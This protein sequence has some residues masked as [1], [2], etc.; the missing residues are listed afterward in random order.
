MQQEIEQKKIA[1][2]GDQFG[3]SM[4]IS[5]GKVFYSFFSYKSRVSNDLSTELIK[6]IEK[7]SI[8]VLMLMT[9]LE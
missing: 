2:A 6:K 9:I 8:Q 4:N 1:S 3:A 7:I 5:I